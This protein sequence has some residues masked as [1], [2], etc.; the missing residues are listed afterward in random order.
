MLPRHCSQILPVKGEEARLSRLPS[1]A[2]VALFMAGTQE[3]RWQC[4]AVASDFLLLAHAN[5]VCCCRPQII[6]YASPE[7]DQ[8]PFFPKVTGGVYKSNRSSL[9]LLIVPSLFILGFWKANLH[10][11]DSNLQ[12]LRVQGLLQ[13]N[14]FPTLWVCYFALLERGSERQKQIGGG[15]ILGGRDGHNEN[16]FESSLKKTFLL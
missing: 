12:G 7:G 16:H 11:Y 4:L 5:A 13:M 3:W 6:N 9:S 2:V 8:L 15:K 1:F 10:R 14:S